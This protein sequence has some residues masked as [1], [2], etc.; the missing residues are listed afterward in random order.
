MKKIVLILVSLFVC[1]AV[2]QA[3]NDKPIELNKL[4]KVAQ[5]F[6]QNNFND[7]KVAYAKVETDWWT[8]T[9]KVVFTNGESAEFDGK[10]Q[11]TEMELRNR[12]VPGSLVPLKVKLYVR[13]NHP[14][15]MIV[16]IEHNKKECEVKLAN[17]L[18]LSFN[19]AGTLKEID[20]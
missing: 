1:H 17:G 16:R 13:Q 3:D 9:Y 10:G 7:S 8:K 11:W 6:I 20:N 2:V 15:E 4:P 12:A 19:A 5:E 18:E 14:G